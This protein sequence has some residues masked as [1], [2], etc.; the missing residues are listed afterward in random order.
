MKIGEVLRGRSTLSRTEVQ[1]ELGTL[2]S[3]F[4]GREDEAGGEIRILVDKYLSQQVGMRS[5][6]ESHTLQRI[7]V[8]DHRNGNKTYIEFIDNKPAI[9]IHQDPDD[10]GA[11]K[12]WSPSDVEM[13]ELGP[14][15]FKEFNIAVD[16]HDKRKKERREPVVIDHNPAN[17]Y[18]EDRE[19]WKEFVLTFGS[20]DGKFD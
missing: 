15:A 20:G 12:P 17:S 5:R 11:P 18:G 16:E 4:P 9:L 6:S 14:L 3:N 10:E 7:L 1:V 2:V 19:S 8:K 13:V